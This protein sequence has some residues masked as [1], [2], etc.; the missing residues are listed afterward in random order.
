MTVKEKLLERLETN[1][2]VTFAYIKKDGSLRPAQGTRMVGDYLDEWD[3]SRDVHTYHDNIKE[4]Y[5][6]FKQG[7]SILLFDNY[8]NIERL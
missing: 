8:K 7:T 6:C 1:D 5:R 4:D 2:N 3:D